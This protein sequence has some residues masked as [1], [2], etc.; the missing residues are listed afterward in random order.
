MERS[1]PI[2]VAAEVGERR[3]CFFHRFFDFD[4][5]GDCV[6]ETYRHCVAYRACAIDC[7]QAS[8]SNSVADVRYV[9]AVADVYSVGGKIA[10]DGCVVVRCRDGDRNVAGA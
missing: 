4:Y 1:A 5:F 9:N 6:G 2:G 3:R 8:F 10:F 7:L